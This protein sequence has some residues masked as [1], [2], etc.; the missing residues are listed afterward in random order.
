MDKSVVKASQDLIAKNNVKS[1]EQLL[2]GG[3]LSGLSETQRLEYVS[4]ICKFSGVSILTKPFDY[5]VLNNK[6]VLYANRSCTEQLRRINKISIKIVGRERIGNELYVVTADATGPRGKTDSSIG[7]VNI[8]GLRG[9][10]LANAMM[11]AET[12][13]KRRVTLSIC[14]LGML[15]EIEAKEMAEKEAREAVHEAIEKVVE[16][17]EESNER[18]EFESIQTL[19]AGPDL[20]MEPPTSGDYILKAGKIQGKKLRDVGFN[21]LTDWIKWFDK[22]KALGK[23]LHEDIE[24]DAFAITQFLADCMMKKEGK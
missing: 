21:K 20:P 10:D 15:D 13:A 22:Q 1:L 17:I 6:L 5:I 19:A 16:K 11:K 8:T 3:D 4:K 23:T 7:A 2:I 24:L 14:G 12:K 9:T 18:P